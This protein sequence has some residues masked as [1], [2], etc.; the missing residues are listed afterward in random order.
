MSRDVTGL[1]LV[2]A[3]GFEP[4]TPCAQG[5]LEQGLEVLISEQFA[6]S[7]IWCGHF[8]GRLCGEPAQHVVILGE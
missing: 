8:C 5:M 4:A 2:G 7:E 6:V 3:A 1:L